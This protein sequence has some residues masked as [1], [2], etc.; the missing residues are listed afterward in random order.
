MCFWSGATV[1]TAPQIQSNIEIDSCMQLL[2]F[3]A[4]LACE[5]GFRGE[6]GCSHGYDLSSTEGRGLYHLG[7]WPGPQ[8]R[9]TSLNADA[10]HGVAWMP[11]QAESL[12]QPD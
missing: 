5:N 2:P 4:S 11:R 9:G 8:C 1:K 7:I 6:W 3:R 10:M 12:R